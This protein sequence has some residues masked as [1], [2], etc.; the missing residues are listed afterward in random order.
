MSYVTSSVDAMSRLTKVSNRSRT[1]I[2][3]LKEHISSITKGASNVCHY[4]HSI[5]LVADELALVGHS[6]DDSNLVIVALNGL[7]LTYLEF[8][9]RSPQSCHS[10]VV[11]WTFWQTCWRWDFSSTE[12]VT[13]II[14]PS[15]CKQCFSFIFLSMLSPGGA[16][17]ARSNPSS[18]H[19]H[20]SFSGS[21]LIY[22]YC[23]CGGHTSKACYKLYGYP[24]NHSRCHANMVNK[25]SGSKPSWHLDLIL[26]HLTMSLEI[27]LVSL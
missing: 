9:C 26:V 1:R 27:L 8:S 2:M 16:S 22:Q 20:N 15:Y 11:W 25:D 7:A 14:L 10:A 13:I 21:R 19:T 6:I 12:G 3:Y 5:R 23:D 4:L 18:S 24:S 17:P